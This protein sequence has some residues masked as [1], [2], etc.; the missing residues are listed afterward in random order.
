MWLTR[1]VHQSLLIEVVNDLVESVTGK[2]ENKDQ[3]FGANTPNRMFSVG[4]DVDRRTRSNLRFVTVNLNVTVAAD[5]VI[6]L[7]G[8]VVMKG[9]ARTGWELRYAH[10]ESA[11]R[12]SFSADKDL[13]ANLTFSGDG[14]VIP[15]FPGERCLIDDNGF[16]VAHNSFPLSVLKIR[17]TSQTLALQSRRTT[18]NLRNLCRNLRL[19]C[20]VALQNQVV[21]QLLRISG[22]V[23]HRR[24]TCG[25]LSG[26]GVE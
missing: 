14:R 2:G 24:H 20:P 6:C 3:W 9:E 4:R 8:L 21:N 11:A 26:V 12:S 15:T 16:L 25:L 5:D 22:R 7:F 23:F 1:D 17:F 19:A 10:D 18:H 13:P